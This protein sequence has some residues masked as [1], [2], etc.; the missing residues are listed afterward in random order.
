MRIIVLTF[1][2]I[3]KNVGLISSPVFFFIFSARAGNGV[4]DVE[5]AMDLGSFSD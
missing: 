4:A 1:L 5:E 2:E 3:P